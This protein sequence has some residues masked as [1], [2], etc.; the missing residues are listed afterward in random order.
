MPSSL[1]VP[2]VVS[3]ADKMRY[4]E[5]FKKADVSGSGF[6]NGQDIKDIFLQSGVPQATLAHIWLVHVTARCGV[7]V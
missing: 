5:M 7:V 2:W 3:P 1:P 6:V 4:D